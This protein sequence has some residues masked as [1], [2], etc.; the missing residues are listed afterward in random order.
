MDQVA[1]K[2]AGI[3]KQYRIGQVQARYKTLRETI[4]DAITTP[5]RRAGQLMKGNLSGAADL[6]ETI[7]ALKDVSFEVK[8]GETVGIVGRN[9]AGK[10]TFL[11]ILSRI[12]TPTEGYAMIAGRVGALLEVGTGFHP[13]LTGRENIYLYGAILGMK[14]FEIDRDLDSILEFSEIDKQ[15]DTPLKH[16]SSGM[17]MRLAFAVAAHLKP[18]ILLVDEVLAVGDAKFQKKCL[19]KMDDVAHQGKTVF[20]VSHNMLA[21]ESLCDRAIW[22]DK[23]R[24]VA[25]GPATEIVN[26]YI[27]STSTAITE[28]KWDDIESAPGNEEVRL[29]RVSVYPENPNE[30]DNQ[31]RVHSNFYIE[32]E[33][34]NFKPDSPLSVTLHLINSHGI[35]LTETG[36]WRNNPSWGAAHLSE[37]LFR[38]SCLFPGHLLNAGGYSVN[39]LFVSGGRVP[40]VRK[41]ALSFDVLDSQESRGGAFYGTIQGVIRPKLEWSTMQLEDFSE[42]LPSDMS[43]T[44]A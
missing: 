17:Q 15:I 26:R 12:T 19:N 21:I 37:G 29:R 16:Y 35:F 32:V 28:E 3:G 39:L 14:K 6:D 44:G 30:L 4:T 41:S 31:I 24:V 20:F 23:G 8:H 2:L 22:L 42:K 9:G 1:I 18:E 13:E 7:W 27:Q 33:Y 10:S 25:D 36:S 34:W 43:K 5:F 11:K 38:S 40:Y